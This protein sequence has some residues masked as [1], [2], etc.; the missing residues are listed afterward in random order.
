VQESPIEIEDKS[1]YHGLPCWN[2]WI[3]TAIIEMRTVLTAQV[4]MILTFFYPSQF[5][6]HNH[7]YLPPKP[8]NSNIRHLDALYYNWYDEN[9]CI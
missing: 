8:A 3:I 9:L 1:F 4:A 7:I 6:K 5:M 2:R